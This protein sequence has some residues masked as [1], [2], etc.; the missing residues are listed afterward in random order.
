MYVDCALCTVLAAGA[1]LIML[2]PF[3]T[4]T[5]WPRSAPL[6]LAPL[7]TLPRLPLSVRSR[8][9]GHDGL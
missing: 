7:T 3:R 4:L 6:P 2:C 9:S 5:Q 1:E 8:F